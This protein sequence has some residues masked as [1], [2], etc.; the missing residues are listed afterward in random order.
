M[1]IKIIPRRSVTIEAWDATQDDLLRIGTSDR[2]TYYLRASAPSYG[3]E[4]VF[5][6]DMEFMPSD[7]KKT[8][9]EVTKH[10]IEWN[11][12]DQHGYSVGDVTHHPSDDEILETL[13]DH[14]RYYRLHELDYDLGI[15]VDLRYGSEVRQWHD[16]NRV[17]HIEWVTR[18]QA[19]AEIAT[20]VDP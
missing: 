8:A 11:S 7:L 1:P 14:H 9:L 5:W 12:R 3:S 15:S 10:E 4:P 16:Y 20:P 19:R 2:K 18:E 17:T 13:K 6:F